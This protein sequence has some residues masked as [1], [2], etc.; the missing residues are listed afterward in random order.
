MRILLPDEFK[1]LTKYRF[2]SYLPELCDLFHEKVFPTSPVSDINDDD[3]DIIIPIHSQPSTRSNSPAEGD[4]N[5][6][7]PRSM[8]TS[9]SSLSRSRSLSVSLQQERESQRDA[10]NQQKRKKRALNREVSMSRVFRA[11]SKAPTPASDSAGMA[12]GPPTGLGAKDNFS[13][14]KRQSYALAKGKVKGKA[15]AVDESEITLVE[16]TPALNRTKSF[17]VG[18]SIPRVELAPGIEGAER[19]NADM[20][21]DVWESE[22]PKSRDVIMGASGTDDSDAVFVIDTPTKVKRRPGVTKSAVGG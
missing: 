17:S 20:D 7:L 3:A 1:D 4:P 6:A 8:S 11:K 14:D 19:E 12:F 18:T 21:M 22:L 16:A 13:K 2:R 5:S 9:S 15:K 10:T